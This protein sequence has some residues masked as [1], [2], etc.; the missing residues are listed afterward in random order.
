M[1][2][3][4]MKLGSNL[5]YLI[6]FVSFLFCFSSFAE[7]EITSTPL[8]N[9]EKLKP[10]FEEAENDIVN[11]SNSKKIKNKKKIIPL[12]ENLMQL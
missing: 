9:L 3:K 10:S 2:K 4:N 1:L 7:N 5:K 11:T 6:T 12:K 8:I